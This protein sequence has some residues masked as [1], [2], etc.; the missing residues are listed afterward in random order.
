MWSTLLEAS[1]TTN[2]IYKEKAMRMHLLTRELFPLLRVAFFDPS[3]S[4]TS[5]FRGQ[6]AAKSLLIGNKILSLPRIDC[7]GGNAIGE[8]V[9]LTVGSIEDNQF[10]GTRRVIDVSGDGPNTL[11]PSIEVVRA[12]AVRKQITIN[13]LAIERPSMPDLP[14]YFKRSVAGGPGSF[15]M[16]VENRSAFAKAILRKILREIADINVLDSSQSTR[17]N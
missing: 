6:V 17:L 1:T 13:A 14:E 2:C 5:N 7:F 12:E 15:V 9:A 3:R 16:K 10:E 8:A 4:H 11:A